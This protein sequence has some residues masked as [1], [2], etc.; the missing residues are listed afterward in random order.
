MGLGIYENA[1]YVKDPIYLDLW[2]Y[3]KLA[4]V[5]EGATQW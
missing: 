5:S 3:L 4:W 1:N 2:E